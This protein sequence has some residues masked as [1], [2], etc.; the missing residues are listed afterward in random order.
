M[1]VGVDYQSTQGKPTGIGVYARSLCDQ[2]ERLKLPVSFVY[3]KKCKNQDLNA[4]Q[5]ILWEN[6]QIPLKT[7]GKKM[8][9]L[10][11]PGFSPPV[12][13]FCPRVVTV[14]DI[15]GRVYPSNQGR[16]AKFYWSR[17]QPLAL[18]NAEKIV[19]S[20]E[21]TRRDL[22]QFL[23]VPDEKIE[24][25]YLGARPEFSRAVEAAEVSAVLARLGIEEPYVLSVSS[26]EPRKNVLGALSAFEKARPFVPGLKLILVGKPAGAQADAVRFIQEKNLSSQVKMI[27][28]VT[29]ADLLCLYHGAIAYLM[30]SYYE[31]FGY[32]V[33]EAMACGLPGVVSNRS[34]LPEVAGDAALLVDPDDQGQIV[35]AL[36]DI[37][38]D[39]KLRQSLSALALQRVRRFSL[40]ETARKMA[41]IFQKTVNFNG[42]N[43]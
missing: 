29:D 16:G 17:W 39:S 1:R 21:S 27:G 42:K 19:A 4:A 22:R 33:L 32:P 13:S 26:I 43:R 5:R 23:G 8:D 10:Y 11:S 18:Q 30:L 12:F 9:V 6:I 31:G 38:T 24:V 28:Y 41:E 35:S 15:I 2:I 7:L 36:K 40:E 14:H 37:L 25:V 3:L 20:S 34:S